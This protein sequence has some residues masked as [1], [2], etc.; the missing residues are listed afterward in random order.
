[1]LN[2]LQ[3]S[4]NESNVTHLFHM[5]ARLKMENTLLITVFSSLDSHCLVL[6]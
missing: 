5:G 4:G 3:R 2:P 6:L 1:M